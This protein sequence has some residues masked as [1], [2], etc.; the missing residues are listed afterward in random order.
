M[1]S[2]LKD[3]IA[4][5][6]FLSIGGTA[7]YIFFLEQTLEEDYVGDK[8]VGRIVSFRNESIRIPGDRTIEFRVRRPG[9]I[10][11]YETVKVGRKTGSAITF[12]LD[13]DFYKTATELTLHE[14]AIIKFTP[15]G[16]RTEGKVSLKGDDG[17]IREVEGSFQATVG[18]SG[19]VFE[20]IRISLLSPVNGEYLTTS[21]RQSVQF[22]WSE[23]AG[24]TGKFLQISQKPDFERILQEVEIPEGQSQ[25]TL[26]FQPGTWYW[27]IKARAEGRDYFGPESLFTVYRYRTPFVREPADGKQVSYW[28]RL[29]LDLVWDEA[30][31]DT[32]TE[33]K[34]ADVYQ[35]ELTRDGT[36]TDY[37]PILLGQKTRYRMTED[38]LATDGNYRFRVTPVFNFISDLASG[39][40]FQQTV[41][42]GRTESGFTIERTEDLRP[43]NLEYPPEGAVFNTLEAKN[44][45]NYN[46][47]KDREMDRFRITVAA[48]PEFETILASETLEYFTWEQRDELKPGT[49]F[50]RVNGLVSKGTGRDSAVRTFRIKEL[51]GDVAL[52]YPDNRRILELD[53]DNPQVTFRWKSDLPGAEYRVLVFRGKEEKPWFR[54][55][56]AETQFSQNLLAPQNYRWQVLLIDAQGRT[57]KSSAVQE[58]S[59]IRPFRAPL[60]VYPPENGNVD[61]VGEREVTLIWEKIGGADSYLFELW[62][63][64]DGTP[65][66]APVV[67]TETREPLLKL[68]DLALLR[69]GEYEIRLASK[70]SNPPEGLIPVTEP[71]RNRFTVG[72][73]VFFT[74]AELV[75]PANGAGFD[76]LRTR[77]DG[78]RFTWTNPPKMN[79][80]QLEIFSV[81]NTFDPVKTIRTTDTSLPVREL[82]P[83]EYLWRVRSFDDRSREAPVSPFNR[84][85]VGDVPR[86]AGPVVSFPAEGSSVNMELYDSL[87]LA[88]S[89]TPGAEYYTVRLFDLRNNRKIIEQTVKS[90]RYDF[91]ELDQLD[92]G[93]FYVEIQA[94]R[95]NRDVN[96]PIIQTSPVVRSTFS[97]FLKETYEQPNIISPDVQ[98]TR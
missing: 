91:T 97:L 79:A 57:I 74:A 83:G 19:V 63:V 7:G 73:L 67:K 55:N 88:W 70:R 24:L 71:S 12:K 94:F 47:E 75:S 32:G 80:F 27:R 11:L 26:D 53:P 54:E 14:G 1:K 2:L 66:A 77:R 9:D 33:A 95:E 20:V 10:Y 81:S 56:V 3:L 59:T 96:P 5:V 16:F 76:L 34:P 89:E 28:N 45:I 58:F 69:S 85:S 13:P 51:E 50:W 41:A 25:T 37:K 64:N 21:E 72:E 78:L 84:F 86:L 93:T 44:G 18:E 29:A 46:W 36:W 65:A 22:R 30:V 40:S 8:V 61:L 92:V 15:E 31:V 38:L 39:V 60:M 87:V 35:L 42:A 52:V 98:Y 23:D 49:Y 90:T 43:L 6:V 48:D 17:E 62:P 4:L 68:K 82:A